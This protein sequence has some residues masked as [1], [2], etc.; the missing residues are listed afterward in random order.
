MTAASSG[1][2]GDSPGSA[3]APDSPASFTLSTGGL[4]YALSVRLNGRQSGSYKIR[5]RIIFLFAIT[6][7]P[8]FL[9]S[10]FEGN[11]LN[12]QLAIPFVSDPIPYVRYFVTLPILV[13]ADAII[14][15]LIAAVI[16]GFSLSGMLPQSSRTEFQHAFRVMDR[17][18]DSYL[19]DVVILA[20]A[21]L[22]VASVFFSPVEQADGVAGSTWIAVSAGAHYRITYAGWWFYLVASPVLM[23]MLFRWFW[24]FLIWCEFMFRV[25]RIKLDLESSHPDLVGGLGVLRNSQN[26]FLV[27]FFAFGTLLSVSFANEILHTDAILTMAGPLV[28]GFIVVCILITTLP[29]LFFTPQLIL[30]KHRGRIQY[31]AL[32]YRLSRAFEEKWTE[33]IH[34]DTGRK[35][36]EATDSSTVCDYSTVYDVVRSM[37]I[38]PVSVRDYGIQAI[39]LLIPFAPL[40]L[41]EVSFS[42]LVK[43]LV[44]TLL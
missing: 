16:N 6:W 15:P 43:R 7:L 34:S 35:L 14:D 8:V 27:I 24:R 31:G 41:T 32:G 39:V 33:N 36:L 10:A 21:A 28:L 12:R 23:V 11:L 18:N 42:E 13:V 40:V 37:R 3:S 22:F 20:V 26:S 17:R 9:L 1:Q 44:D 38:V 19:A 25:S 4:I 29:L 2:P 5:R 30:T